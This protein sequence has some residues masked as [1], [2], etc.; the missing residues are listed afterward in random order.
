MPGV[1]FVVVVDRLLAHCQS[2]ELHIAYTQEDFLHPMRAQIR[3]QI[4]R[5]NLFLEWN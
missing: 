3:I 2:Q 5:Y 1:V 4:I